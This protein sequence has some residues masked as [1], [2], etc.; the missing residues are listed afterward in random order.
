M[1]PA[2]SKLRRATCV[3]LPNFKDRVVPRMRSN[4]ADMRAGFT[5]SA[6]SVFRK[7]RSDGPATRPQ[8]CAVLGLSR[9][10]LSS[11]VGELDKVGFVEKIGEVKGTLGRRAAIYRLGGRAGHVIAGAAR[12][13]PVRRPRGAVPQ[14]V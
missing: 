13:P 4:D 8:L 6:R 2:L 7:L 10:T 11:S 14:R 3:N 12:P 9:P 5:A 1:R